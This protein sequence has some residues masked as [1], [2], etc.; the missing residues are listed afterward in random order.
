MMEPTECESRQELDAFVDAM[1]QIR[2][3][4]EHE[5]QILKSAPHRTPVR[6]LDEVAAARRP[7]LRWRPPTA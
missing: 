6:R 1:L 5:P 7:R 4:A 3:E 2:H